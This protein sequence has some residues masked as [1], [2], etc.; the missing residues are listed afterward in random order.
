MIGASHSGAIIT[1]RGPIH[2]AGPWPEVEPLLR[3]HARPAL[4]TEGDHS[5][6]VTDTQSARTDS[7]QSGTGQSHLVSRDR[8]SKLE[9]YQ[10]IT[11]MSQY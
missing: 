10:D 8:A 7:G 9:V 3:L 4:A 11:L 5:W 1:T 6:K 2:R